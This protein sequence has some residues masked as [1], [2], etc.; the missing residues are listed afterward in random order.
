MSTENRNTITA[1]Y[2][3]LIAASE[4]YQTAV[5]SVT[6]LLKIID[7]ARANKAQAQADLATYTQRYDD[8][9]KR[10]RE[11]QE[12]IISI[13]I[14]ITQIRSAINAAQDRLGGI[15]AQIADV[16]ATI[17]D[18]EDRNRELDNL[19]DEYEAKRAGLIA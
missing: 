3:S 15:N 7:Q 17:G 16:Q 1:D 14:K 13:E 11:A 10:Q 12:L 2:V 5:K 6:N 18:L 8:A 19:I 9:V 4:R